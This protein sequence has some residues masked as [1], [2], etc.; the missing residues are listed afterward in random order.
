MVIRPAK[1]LPLQYLSK[2]LF[3]FLTGGPALKKQGI[4]LISALV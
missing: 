4:E 1:T 3:I 2:N